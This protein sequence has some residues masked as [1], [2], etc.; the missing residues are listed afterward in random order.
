MPALSGLGKASRDTESRDL[1]P[2][3]NSIFT[4]RLTKADRLAIGARTSHHPA[5]SPPS[6]S[7]GSQQIPLC[8]PTDP[9][10]G[11]RPINHGTHHERSQV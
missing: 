5:S 11:G 1:T 6:G 9:E 7:V 2:C 3:C 4:V 10:R 8:I